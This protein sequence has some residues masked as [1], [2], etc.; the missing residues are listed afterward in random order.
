[1]DSQLRKSIWTRSVALGFVYLILI[2]NVWVTYLITGGHVPLWMRVAFFIGIF[3]VTV[4][5]FGVMAVAY[6]IRSEGRNPFY[7]Q[8]R[9]EDEDDGQSP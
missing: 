8:G 9:Q 4:S 6:L 2:G 1:M 7:P 3:W 5:A